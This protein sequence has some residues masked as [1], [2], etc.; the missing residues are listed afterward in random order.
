MTVFKMVMLVII[1]KENEEGREQI[2]LLVM[3]IYENEEK[4]E[5]I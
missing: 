1:E 5:K 2:T 4:E 3:S